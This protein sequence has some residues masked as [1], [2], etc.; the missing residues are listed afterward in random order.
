MKQETYFSIEP[1]FEFSELSV[2]CAIHIKLDLFLII[3]K[4]F[5][6]GE[7]FPSLTRPEMVLVLVVIVE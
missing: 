4:L 6:C 7:N 3:P 2:F 1:I 5:F